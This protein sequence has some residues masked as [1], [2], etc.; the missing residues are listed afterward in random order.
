MRKK[1]IIDILEKEYFYLYT[2]YGVKKIAVFGSFANNTAGNNSDIDL[3]IEF[4]RPP[5]FKF[6][7]LSD[8]LEKVL[9]RK[10]DILTRDALRAIRVKSVA[11][12]IQRNMLYVKT[13]I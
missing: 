10:V 2:T 3:L 11:K 1:R 6:F 8:Y 9:G 12:N 4:E 5:G 7:E 13:N